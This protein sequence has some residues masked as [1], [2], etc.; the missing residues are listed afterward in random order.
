VVVVV[1]VG[2]WIG[3]GFEVSKGTECSGNSAM[4]LGRCHFTSAI[5]KRSPLMVKMVEAEG[6]NRNSLRG[7]K[8]DGRRGRNCVSW[9]ACCL[10]VGD[11]L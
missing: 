10:P 4:G 11:Y 7:K 3:G 1:V 5:Q 6:K 9:A 8:R 2:R